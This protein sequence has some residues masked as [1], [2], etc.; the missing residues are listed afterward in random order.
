MTQELLPQYQPRKHFLKFHA[1]SERFTVLNVHRGG[2]KT[3]GAIGEIV[4]R[5]GYAQK[6][7]RYVYIAPF[8]NQAKGIVWDIL[9]EFTKHCRESKNE[10]ELEVTL[11]NGAKIFVRGA[12]KPETL[13]G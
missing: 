13:R 4:E 12:D 1:R 7:A 6:G 10:S 3:Y 9:M 11:L 2:G 8:L 5:A